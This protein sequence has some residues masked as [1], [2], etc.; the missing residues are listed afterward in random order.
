M[1]FI[2]FALQVG[3]WAALV[4]ILYRIGWTRTRNGIGG[5]IG[6]AWDA[7]LIP[8]EAVWGLR[9]ALAWTAAIN[10]LLAV[11]LILPGLTY[12][13]RFLVGLGV[14]SFGTFLALIWALAN[15]LTWYVT[16]I[17]RIAASVASSVEKLLYNLLRR[18]LEASGA[19]QADSL[20]EAGDVSAATETFVSDLAKFRS[21]VHL[22]FGSITFAW[23]ALGSFLTLAP[24]W[25]TFFTLPVIGVLVLCLVTLG[26]A[27][28]QTKRGVRYARVAGVGLLGV[29]AAI[30]IF[31]IV[32]VRWDGVYSRLPAS[33]QAIVRW[34]DAT[35]DQGATR[36]SRRTGDKLVDANMTVAVV[37]EDTVLY[38][39]RTSGPPSAGI[40]P[41]SSTPL[42]AGTRLALPDPHPQLTTIGAEPMYEV[43]VA[44]NNGDFVN[45]ANRGW[46]VARKV[47]LQSPLPQPDT[48]L[49]RTRWR[50]RLRSRTVLPIAV[51]ALIAAVGF[52]IATK[53]GG[54][55]A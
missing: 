23:F 1:T 50:P 47:Q 55:N 36:I 11:A 44:N 14:I 30:S 37:I 34:L 40:P 5:L 45:S 31:S 51:I 2:T 41:T 3:I 43:I 9:R 27:F 25:D 21:Y 6:L 46:V 52:S 15:S 12:E 24:Y 32:A 33:T 19:A 17:G 48:Q 39:Y 22:T 4:V 10:T 16:M 26:L 38:A 13:N 29:V 7:S 42:P 20:P 35:N 49:G 18:A 8:L 28:D 53:K 54:V